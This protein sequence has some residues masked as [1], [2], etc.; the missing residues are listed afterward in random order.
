M[1]PPV[2]PLTVFSCLQN[3]FDVIDLSDNMIV[4]LEGFPKLPRLGTLF[5][6]NNRVMRIARHLEGWA[7]SF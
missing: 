6:N 1:T 5:V 4:I 3:Q 7:P 2:L